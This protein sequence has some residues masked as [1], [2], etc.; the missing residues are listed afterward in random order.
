MIYSES[1]D[2]ISSEMLN[3]FF[4]GW[5]MFPTTEKHLELL[6]CSQYRII[7]T[8]DEKNI[9]V[10]FITAVSDKV[11]SAYIPFLEVLPLYHNKGIGSELVKRMLKLLK[12]YYMIDKVCDD[13]L[14]KFY[15]K[16]GLN[17][18]NAMMIRN[19]ENQNGREKS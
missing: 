7:A 10:G 12:D 15:E 8:D 17:K 19:Y 18:H 16:A 9:V 3:G 1:A 14:Q 6:K 4:V 5:K 13:S 2:N 11:L